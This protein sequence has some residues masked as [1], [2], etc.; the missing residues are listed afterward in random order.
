MG[1]IYSTHVEDETSTHILVRKVDGKIPFGSPW[2]KLNTGPTETDPKKCASL[3]HWT[4]L[5]QNPVVWFR[6][7]ST[8]MNLWVS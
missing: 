2:R 7:H 4:A 5:W 1:E 8:V 3:L 6:E